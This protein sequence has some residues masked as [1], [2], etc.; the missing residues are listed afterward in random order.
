MSVTI[1][2]ANQNKGLAILT[3]GIGNNKEAEILKTISRTFN[4][5]GYTTIRFDT[6]NAFEGESEGKFENATITKHQEDLEDIINWAKKQPWHKEPFILI[7]HSVGGLCAGTHAKKFPSETKGLILISSMVSGELTSK[8][9]SQP[10][11]EN[12]EKTGFFEWE[13]RGKIKKLNWEAISDSMDKDLL[14][15][16]ETLTMPTLIIFGNND[17]NALEKHQ[18]MLYDKTPEPK[19]IKIIK[20]GDHNLDKPKELAEIQET[21]EEWIAKL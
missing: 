7:G 9:Y 12:W 19:K 3:H 6:T 10:V 8:N 15:N 1:E 11:L 18:Q 5:K 20:D 17:P 2:E 14:K 21:V 16:I 13:D 4:S